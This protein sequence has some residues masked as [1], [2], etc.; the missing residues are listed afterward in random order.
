MTHACVLILGS[1]PAGCTAAIYTARAGRKTVVVAGPQAGGQLTQ[2]SDIENF[3]EIG[4]A[5]V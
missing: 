2:T 3:P 5:H 4:R 1:G